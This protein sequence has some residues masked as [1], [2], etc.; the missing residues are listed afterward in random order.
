MH[1]AGL[2]RSAQIQA[3]CCLGCSIVENAEAAYAMGTAFEGNALQ[4]DFTSIRVNTIG[5]IE[6]SAVRIPAKDR[7]HIPLIPSRTLW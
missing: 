1:Q 3:V 4:P 2:D 5:A 6:S 7:A